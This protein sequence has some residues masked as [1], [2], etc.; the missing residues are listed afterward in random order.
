MTFTNQL[1]VE[2]EAC[3]AGMEERFAVDCNELARRIS[4]VEHAVGCV[5]AGS[6]LGDGELHTAEV[7][8][9]RAANVHGVR[10]YALVTTI[11]G[12]LIIR[13]DRRVGAFSNLDGI[14]DMVDV[15]VSDQ[16]IVALNFFRCHRRFR[17]ALQEG[18]E[19]QTMG[20]CLQQETRMAPVGQLHRLSF[21]MVRFKS[22]VGENFSICYTLR[23]PF[24][25]ETPLTRSEKDDHRMRVVL[26]MVAA[27][28][29]PCVYAED[30]ASRAQS[31][32][33]RSLP[34]LQRS[35][36]SYAAQRSCFS[37][38]HQG[39]VA[40][41]VT[42][43]KARGFYVDAERIREQS[44]FTHDYFTERRDQVAA[45]E[46]VPGGAYNTGYALL[47]LARDNWQPDT[48][49]DA[50]IEYLFHKQEDNGRWRIR[51]HRPPLEDSDFTATALSIRALQLYARNGRE[52]EMQKR[53]AHAREWL[54]ASTP[55][56]TED[57]AFYLL[58]L[59]WSKSPK[60]AIDRAAEQLLSEQRDEGGWAQLA[61]MKSDAYAT[62]QVLWALQRGG[63]LS[64]S[65][66]A[67]RR[68]IEFLL[69]TQEEDGSWKVVTR[70]KPIQT[71]FET[72]FPHGKSQFI[73]V[74]GTSWATMVLSLS[75]ESI[76][77]Q[78][79]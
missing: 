3:V 16:D 26:F 35:A 71:Y 78:R 58:G 27:L 40:L 30:V 46:G 57:K 44:V 23:Q 17:V 24:F 33:A 9:V 38:H 65:N 67:Y 5:E 56:T 34:L 52:E 64:V 59:H 39:L 10:R 4:H 28:I 36:E 14:T 31:A 21:V 18:I 79:F 15:T 2:E 22:V 68:G 7:E 1:H 8:V 77:T 45:G 69:Q 29:A 50:L 48:T 72:D 75:I 66:E 55:T 20:S 63:G 32:V 73:S 76:R 54:G 11:A 70:S 74:C 62:G 41:A 47:S 60:E 61:E 43:A 49:T 12:Y 51:T 19:N 13:D 25:D 42:A 37:C 53:I 6:V